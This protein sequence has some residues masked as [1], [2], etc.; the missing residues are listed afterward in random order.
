MRVLRHRHLLGC[1]ALL[2]FAMQGLLALAQ[3]HTHSAAAGK[4]Q[5]AARAI[6]YGMCKPGSKTPCVPA[7]PH[8]DHGKCDLCLSVAVA[9]GALLQAPPAIL[10]RHPTRAAPKP[11]RVA[12]LVDARPPRYFQA[13]AP[14]LA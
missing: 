13:R 8:N 4:S 12:R 6:T 14:P 2:V 1:L 7:A 9:S 10:P 11:A 3:T 5:L